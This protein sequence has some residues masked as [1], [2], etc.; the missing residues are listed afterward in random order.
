MFRSWSPWITGPLRFLIGAAGLYAVLC[1]V[2]FLAQRRLMYFPEREGETEAIHRALGHGL[3]PWSDARGRLLGW[4]RV[5]R[6][7]APRMLVLHGNAGDALGREGYLAVLEAAGFEVVLLEYPGYG[8]REGE[9]SEASLVADARAALRRLR[10][11]SKTPVFLLGESLGSGVAVQVAAAERG[12]VAG[13]LLT[14]PF[15]RMTEVAAQHYPY[16]PMGL[17]L[18]DRWDSLGAV[19]G[20]PG[21]VAMIVAG[22]DEVVGAEQGRRLAKGCPG[23]VR[24]WEIPDANHNGL[25]LLP[26]RPPW[27]EALA[28]LRSHVQTQGLG[29]AQALRG[30]QRGDVERASASGRSPLS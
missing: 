14:V 16:L 10:E 7:Q 17:L 13:L 27:S 4:R 11:E 29:S 28:F 25:P 5:V 24:V 12:A 1:A 23:A 6:R 19:R 3:V 26:G 20:Y 8:P 15:A 9:R 2:A 30:G 18:K 21:P 22:R